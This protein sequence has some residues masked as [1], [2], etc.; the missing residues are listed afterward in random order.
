LF[1][2]EITALAGPLRFD[3]GTVLLASAAPVLLVVLAC[4]AAWA[5]G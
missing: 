3:R 2:R 1:L 5:L 4:A